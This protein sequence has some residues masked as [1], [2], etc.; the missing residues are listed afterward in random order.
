M[1]SAR[2]A[3]HRLAAA[4]AIERRRAREQQL[5]MVVELRH[6]ADGRARG[7]HRVGLVDGDGRWN[8]RDRIDLRLVH[9]IE[10]LPRV[11]REGLDVTALAFGVQ[12]VENERGLAGAGH[13][14]DDD[15]L[16]ERNVEVEVLEIVLARAAHED[17]ITRGVGHSV[18]GVDIE[19]RERGRRGEQR[20]AGPARGCADFTVNVGSA[21]MRKE[22]PLAA[23]QWRQCMRY[24]IA[25]GRTCRRLAY[26]CG[27]RHSGP[28]EH[29]CR[30]SP[31]A[32]CCR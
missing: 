26:N 5:Q 12:R 23:I 16:V 8:A 14:R 19:S 17:G 20:R 28:E 24:W 15:E 4:L 30:R 9:A 10:K 29:P 25:S 2:V 11:R 22:P 31:T 1:L 32:M 27:F 18:T 7:A 21:A 3:A 13:A 6:R